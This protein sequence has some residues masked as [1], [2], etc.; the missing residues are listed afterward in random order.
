[1]LSLQVMLQSHCH[2][3]AATLYLHVDPHV[4]DNFVPISASCHVPATLSP[5][6]GPA[7][8]TLETR[9]ASLCIGS[10]HAR[11]T[12]CLAGA[13]LCLAGATLLS[14][15]SLVVSHSD[16]TQSARQ[17][18]LLLVPQSHCH[19]LTATLSY[20]A[21]RVITWN[22]VVTTRHSLTKRELEILILNMFKI[23]LHFYNVATAWN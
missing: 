1:M 21:K 17:A 3:V 19:V 23:Q 4:V 16:K 11:A 7:A 9:C 20:V 13:T 8:A 6:C 12:L 2:V 14:V 5:R 15:C 18:K 22:N 10:R